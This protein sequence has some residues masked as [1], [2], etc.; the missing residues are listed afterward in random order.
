MEK[1]RI[2]GYLHKCI[3]NDF[4]T[5][6]QFEPKAEFGVTSEIVALVDK[7]DYDLLLEEFKKVERDRDRLIRVLNEAKSSQIVID[8][9]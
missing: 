3:G 4:D 7:Y 1:P 2:R 5:F 8:V 9:N 6:H